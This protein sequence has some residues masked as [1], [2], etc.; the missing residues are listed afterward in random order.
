VCLHRSIAGRE[1]PLL[2]H[3]L[4]KSQVHQKRVH[5]SITS[6]SITSVSAQEHC[7][8]WIAIITPWTSKILHACV[9]LYQNKRWHRISAPKLSTTRVDAENN[10]AK[11]SAFSA[12]SF[13]ATLRR[14]VQHP[15]R[16][17]ECTLSTH[18]HTHTNTHT[19]THTHTTCTSLVHAI[20]PV[21]TLHTH[22]H[23]TAQYTPHAPLR[24]MQHH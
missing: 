20:S 4:A 13:P 1:L 11:T 9:V 12:E 2:L 23:T 8:A 3:G 7:R 10:T 21:P 5:L 16:H 6:P 17:L 22:T 24:S 18:T 19:H 14:S 15:I